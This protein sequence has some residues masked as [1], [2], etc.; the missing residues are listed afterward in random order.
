MSTTLGYDDTGR[1]DSDTT[2]GSATTYAYDTAGQL[3]TIDP[4]VGDTTT[5]VYD[6][7]GRRDTYTVGGNINDVRV[8][9]SLRTPKHNDRTRH[10]HLHMG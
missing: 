2:N 1:I 7:L 8:Q 9:R 6:E 10:N 4:A 5:I 3:T